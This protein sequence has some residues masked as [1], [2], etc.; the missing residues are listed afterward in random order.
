MRRVFVTGGS[1]FIGSRLLRALVQHG[2]S[3]A[4]LDRSGRIRERAGLSPP[5]RVVPGDL[6]EPETY[7]AA[8]ASADVV[9]HLAASTGRASSEEHQR[10]IALGTESLL[11]ECGAA[12][13]QRL[14]FVSSIATTFEDQ[15]GYPYAQAKVRAERAVATSG[16]PH[17]ILRPA[18]V[19]G[20]GSPILEALSTLATLPLIPVFGDG[21]TPVQPV[22]V[23]DVVA[24]ILTVL[25]G[26]LFAN[27][28]VEIGGP[29]TVPIEELLQ[30]IRVAR[31][32]RRGPVCHIP[33]GWL[34][35]ALG[36]AEA[37]GMGRVLP[38]TRG[39]LA[40]FRFPGTAAENPLVEALGRNL[41]GLQAM[42]SPRAPTDAS[43][44]TLEAECRVFT[45]YLVGCLP[46][47]Y[48]AEQYIR[49]HRVS[50][51]LSAADAFD[52]RL[53]SF[54][55][56]R[57]IL[58]RLADS[59]GRVFA[60]ASLLRR[61]LV[62]LLAVL[63]TSPSTYRLIDQPVGGNRLLLGG[64][65]AAKGLLWLGGLVAGTVLLF[66]ARLALGRRKPR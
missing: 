35:P 42:A 7:R 4:A 8:L 52:Q 50:F 66:P 45:R 62:L 6:L 26:D 28:I 11:R 13:V 59:Y 53:V 37:V 54:A 3:V 33:L 41:V 15:S 27:Q 20:P 44:E 34:L 10:T 19:L 17:L 5:S 16:V 23:D 56:R 49:A 64:S 51:K 25:E 31:T 60:P 57:R 24:F 12:G 40:T 63:E 22:F 65:L 58:T 61:K 46:T 1:G 21:R 43:A 36:A 29:E 14:L 32:G 55:A 39:Q 9:V 48:V 18:M 38:M 30:V 47:S 2:Y